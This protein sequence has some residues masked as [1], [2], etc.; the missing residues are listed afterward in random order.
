LYPPDSISSEKIRACR[1]PRWVEDLA[2]EEIRWWE[3]IRRQEK[4]M[5]AGE[6]HHA[7]TSANEHTDVR[8]SN[9]QFLTWPRRM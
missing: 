6:R 5:V 8:T 2:A 9:V 3:E 1:R 4:T 7:G